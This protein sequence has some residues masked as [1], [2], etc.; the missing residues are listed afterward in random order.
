MTASA[1]FA[2]LL[3]PG[4]SMFE[5]ENITKPWRYTEFLGFNN[6]VIEPL[7][8]CRTEYDWIRELAGRIGLEDAFTEGRDYEQWLRYLYEDL[9]TR[10]PAV[11]YTHL[12]VYKRQADKGRIFHGFG[13]AI[14]LSGI[15][16]LAGV[17]HVFS[18]IFAA[19][20][21]VTTF[22]IPAAGPAAF[23][24]EKFYLVFLRLW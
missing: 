13:K 21:L 18:E 6:K 10:E 20:D 5:E 8:E 2:D 23:V 11:S 4:V 19:D 14:T 17:L 16:G 24:A 12:D 15:R 7:S 3:L 9:R 22:A 1:R